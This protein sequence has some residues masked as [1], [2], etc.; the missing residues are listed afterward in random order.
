MFVVCRMNLHCFVAFFQMK[1]KNY[2]Q[3]E[4]VIRPLWTWIFV[5]LKVCKNWSQNTSKIIDNPVLRLVMQC[6]V[7]LSEGVIGGG[8]SHIKLRENARHLALGCKLQILVLL[9]VF[10][11]EGHYI[12]PFKYRLVLCTKK[13]TKNALTL[14]TQQFHPHCTLLGA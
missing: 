10:G 3:V 14:I 5:L 6:P 2:E 9:R 7:K 4:K 13:F 11:V 8:G 12:C 1:N